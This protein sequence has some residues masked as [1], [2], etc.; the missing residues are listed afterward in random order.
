M[1]RASALEIVPIANPVLGSP[2]ALVPLAPKTLNPQVH[3]GILGLGIPRVRPILLGRPEHLRLIPPGPPRRPLGPETSVFPP[4]PVP[5]TMA[6]AVFLR[7]LLAVDP[8]FPVPPMHPLRLTAAM[9][10]FPQVLALG[11]PIL[12]QLVMAMAQLPLPIRAMVAF[13]VGA[14][15]IDLT[16]ALVDMASV[17]SVALPTPKTWAPAVLTT[18]ELTLQ[19]A[20]IGMAEASLQQILLLIVQLG[21]APGAQA[22]LFP[23]LISP[24]LTAG[25][26]PPSAIAF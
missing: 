22:L 15:P 2:A 17:P 16:M 10:L 25:A 6:M 18:A 24:P 14:S 11:A 13:R 9:R 3:M 7:T 12:L 20:Q 23:E 19:L 5:M 1:L 4:S 26:A 21:R 8:E